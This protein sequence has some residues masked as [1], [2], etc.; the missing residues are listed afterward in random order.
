MLLVIVAACGLLGSVVV[1]LVFKDVINDRRHLAVGPTGLLRYGRQPRSECGF[2][3]AWFCDHGGYRRAGV[4]SLH[5]RS[6]A[7]ADSIIVKGRSN[8]SPYISPHLV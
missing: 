1:L 5:P 6:K 4:F 3:Y 7:D 2:A 8:R